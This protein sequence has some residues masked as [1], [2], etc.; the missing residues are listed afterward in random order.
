MERNSGVFK[1]I[2]KIA[3]DLIELENIAANCKL[4]ELCKGQI[5]PVFAKGNEEAD[6]IICGMCPGPDE[7]RV[8]I[9]FVGPAG[10]ILDEIMLRAF[11][12]KN[13]V[14]ITNLIKCY[15]SPGTILQPEWMNVCLPYF[16]VQLKIIK[17]KIIIALGKDISNFLLNKNDSMGSMRGNVYDY[18]KIKLI[19]TYHPAFLARGNFNKFSK[20]VVNDFKKALNFI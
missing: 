4:C 7:N 20:I 17:P 15:V 16:I 5:K 11:T 18:M 14:Y 9:P 10:K 12:L 6:I 2:Q 8:G 13:K 19:S 1:R 3:M